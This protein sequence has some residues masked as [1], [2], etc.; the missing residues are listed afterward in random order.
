MRHLPVSPR[1][2]FSTA[3]GLWLVVA[4]AVTAWGLGCGA[5]DVDPAAPLIDPNVIGERCQSDVWCGDA[6]MTC[7]LNRPGGFCSVPCTAEGG[8][9][10]D[11]LCRAYPD[12]NWC[13]PQCTS[14]ADCRNG[15]TCASIGADDGQ[16]YRVCDV[17]GTTTPPG[18]GVPGPR[19]PGGVADGANGAT[20]DPAVDGA[21]TAPG[22]K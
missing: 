12:G 15:Y 8:C 19:E 16:I 13:V 10:G 9:P 2:R 17:G 20:D 1:S 11:T 3:P 4:V 14:D 21:P 5:T 7:L 18:S 6:P 22:R